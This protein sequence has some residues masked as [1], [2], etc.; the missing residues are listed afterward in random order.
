MA[1]WLSSMQQT[2][3]YYTV[4]PVTWKDDKLLEYVTSCTINRD[5][6]AETLGSATLE[7]TEPIDEMYIRIYL[8]TIQNGVK[9]KHPLGTFL[10]QTPSSG[11]D[12]KVKSISVDAYTPLL[13][14]KEKQPALGY[15]IFRP[16]VGSDGKLQNDEPIMNFVYRLTDEYARAKVVP[17]T[18]D[19]KLTN[20][21][22]ANTDDTWLTFL[23]DLMA[24]AKYKFDLDEM[25]R[26][27]FKPDQETA[28]LQ[29]VWTYNDGNSSILQPDV[30]INR[31][32]YGI[33][34]VVE[35][36]YSN[37][38]KR[39]YARKSNDDPNSPTSTVSRGREI[40]QR[41]TDPK[42]VGVPSQEEVDEYATKTLKEAST[43][44]YSVT[45][46]HGYCPVRVGDCV[47]LNYSRAGL[48]N[49]KAKVVSQSIKCEPGCQVTEKVV[50]TA[51]LWR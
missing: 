49:I 27:M 45:Y 2:Y 42:F 6:T 7:I 26:I 8:I 24:N 51:E 22:V 20:N 37:G 35:V 41:I 33:P 15:S 13:E 32:I 30:T 16:Y 36:I 46:T 39:F 31:D 10:A 40:I 21:F 12:G 47:M 9:E 28:K 48:K 11:F 50:F 5:S 17:V 43:I 34:N 3:E 29:P 44:E 18:H 25:G 1:D 4:D 14:L 19:K 38:L 23:T